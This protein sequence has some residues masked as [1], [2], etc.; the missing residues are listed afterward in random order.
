[1]LNILAYMFLESQI[2]VLSIALFILLFFGIFFYIIILKNLAC[3][4]ILV[5]K[6]YADHLTIGLTAGAVWLILTHLKEIYEDI[7]LLSYGALLHFLIAILLS[8]F[9]ITLGCVIFIYNK[10]KP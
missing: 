3:S 2:W 7:N 5:Y 4:H 6:K 10:Q 8:L 9:V 1:M